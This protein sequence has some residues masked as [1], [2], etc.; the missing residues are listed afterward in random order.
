MNDEIFPSIN[1]N[2]IYIVVEVSYLLLV[3]LYK[4]IVPL[5]V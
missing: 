4:L 2:K 1:I 3:Y 5:I